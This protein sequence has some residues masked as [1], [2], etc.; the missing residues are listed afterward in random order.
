MERT[1]Y[2]GRGIPSPFAR[3]VAENPLAQGTDTHTAPKGTGAQTLQD[4]ETTDRPLGTQT[5]TSPH[6]TPDLAR[7]TNTRTSPE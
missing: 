4:S 7:E 3:T 5:E 6:P 2:W 1:P